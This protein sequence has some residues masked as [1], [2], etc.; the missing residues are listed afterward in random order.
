MGTMVLVLTIN[1]VIIVP[2]II[3]EIDTQVYP[4]IDKGLIN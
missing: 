1:L 3:F 2:R 4:E